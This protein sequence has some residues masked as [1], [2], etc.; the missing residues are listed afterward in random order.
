MRSHSSIVGA[1]LLTL[2]GANPISVRASA[3]T[4]VGAIPLPFIGAITGYRTT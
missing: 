3:L 2:A 1:I 4:L